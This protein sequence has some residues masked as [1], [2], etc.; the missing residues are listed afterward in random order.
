MDCQSQ[1]KRGFLFR[2]INNAIDI[3]SELKCSQ[4]NRIYKRLA[5]DTK[6]PKEMTDHISGHSM[7]VGSAQGLM[8]SGA[9]SQ[10]L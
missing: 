9:S 1:V 2:G 4:I 7:Q 3:T 6:L 10:P 5:K 8:K